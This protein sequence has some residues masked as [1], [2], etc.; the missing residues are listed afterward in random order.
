MAERES[1]ADIFME[2]LKRAAKGG[3]PAEQ[4]LALQEKL[5]EIIK[6][7]E[8]LDAYDQKI[9]DKLMKTLEAEQTCVLKL[10]E[11]NYKQEK[12]ADD[13]KAFNEEKF[14]VKKDKELTEALARQTNDK[15]GECEAKLKRLEFEEARVKG[16]EVSLLANKKKVE[17]AIKQ[18]KLAL[19]S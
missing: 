3:S 18:M 15:I 7:K 5:D 6:E 13:T 4:I 19:E 16:L 14:K 17:E 10:A 12:L 2:F 9:S 8:Q 11:V 1:T